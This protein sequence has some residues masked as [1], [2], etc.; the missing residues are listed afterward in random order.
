MSDAS[1]PAVDTNDTISKVMR[2]FE[3]LSSQVVGKHSAPM[4][5]ANTPLV[6]TE[7]SVEE[8]AIIGGSVPAARVLFGATGICSSG[9]R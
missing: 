8:T 3:A 6:F 7:A 4:A 1:D 9:R 2:A 5:D